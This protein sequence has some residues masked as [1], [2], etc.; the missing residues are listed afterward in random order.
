MNWNN[1]MM[2]SDLLPAIPEDGIDNQTA[3]MEIEEGGSAAQESRIEQLMVTMLDERDKLLEQLQESQEHSK[4][5]QE[6]VREAERSREAL[7]RRLDMQTEHL[8]TEIQTLTKELSQQREQLL[9]KDEEI[10]ELKAER[11]NTRLLLEHLECLVSRHERSL[12]MTVMKR[13]NQNS[14]GVSS[15]VEVLKALKSLFEHHKALDEKVRE[16]LRVAMERVAS[17][18]DELNAKSDENCSLKAL[19]AKATAEAE[20]NCQNLSGG[21]GRQSNGSAASAESAAR[22]VELEDQLD[23]MKQELTNSLKQISELTNRNSEIE[24]QASSAQK[25]I[26]TSKEQVAKLKHQLQ[27]ME[28]QR[29]EQEAL[30][31]TLENRYMTAQRE[32]TCLRDLKD[33][34]EH[35]LANNDAAC[36]LNEEK[37]HSLQERLE[38]S[39]K[40]LAQSLKKAES[41]PSVEAELQQR[42]EALTAAEQKQVSAEERVQQ[43]Q[44]QVEERSSELERAVQRE[45][46][47]EEHNQRLSSTVDKLLSES[48][49]RLQLHLKERM[50]ALDEKNRLTQQLEQTKKLYDQAER[51]KD[52]LTRDNENLRQEIEAVRQQLYN[53]RTAQFQSRFSSSYIPA[54]LPQVM[55]IPPYARNQPQMQSAANAPA[56]NAPIYSTLGTR[57]PQKGRV[58]ALADDPTKV[59]TLNEQE[60]DRLQQ[61]HV[62]ANVQQAFSNSSSMLNINP[63]AMMQSSATNI[64]PPNG[65]VVSEPQMQNQPQSS[66]AHAL[67]SMLQER[68]DAINTEIRII[69]Q[70]KSHAER[71]AEQLEHR[72]WSNELGP[73]QPM[74]GQNMY[75]LEEAAHHNISAR[76]TP[77]NSPQHDLLATK[78]STLPA[79]ASTSAYM[80]GHD[81]Y[82]NHMSM[83]D[84]VLDREY[85]MSRKPLRLD[86]MQQPLQGRMT[87]ENDS[88]DRM[89]PASSVS[90]NEPSG[91]ISGKTKKRSSSTSGLKSLGRIFGTKKGKNQ[92]SYRRMMDAGAYSDS[93]MS[94][95]AEGHVMNN[96]ANVGKT[97]NG[98]SSTTASTADFDR[99]KR[100]KHELLE[101]AMKARTPF[102]LWNGPTVVAWLELWVGMPAWYV[103]ACRANVKSGAIMSALSDQ[104]I[105]R[106]IGISNPLHR[107]KLRLAI[108]EMVSLT[109]PS[110]PRNA[111]TTLAFGDMNHEWIGN[112]WLPSLGL[113]KYR[114]AFMECL[115]DA[116]ML[117]HLSKRDLRVHLK[118]VDNF[119]RTSLQYGILCLKKLNYERKILEERRRSCEN[120]NKDVVVWSCERVSRWVEEIGLG[121]FAGQLRDSG[122]HGALIALDETFDAQAF[123]LS[124][125][126]P[127]QD[128]AA[129]QILERH[130][131][132]L[133]AECRS[134]PSNMMQPRHTRSSLSIA[135]RQKRRSKDSSP[136]P[137]SSLEPVVSSLITGEGDSIW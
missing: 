119:H 39:E 1:A 86:H 124:L 4:R 87:D 27:E 109:S 120:V 84:S 76:S 6:Q 81:M 28:V 70:E 57:R 88:I 58:A 123:A 113:G 131:N 55:E 35:Q 99:R 136:A 108:Q 7:V 12:R 20:E 66:D 130:F 67:A 3:S 48:N 61:A 65:P 118:M 51:M 95:A 116:R 29:G 63:N 36:R 54:V 33:K 53:A 24:N 93:E 133:V 64:R 37:V 96:S 73:N 38:L 62:L 23:R 10:V 41:L 107:L 25:D 44:R 49:D 9:E 105:Q 56:V 85:N 127:P 106:E 137:R 2:G 94:S 112:E 78:Y 79:N 69:Q 128:E 31:E 129:R 82:Q 34:L 40:Q 71:V 42:M 121:L 16:R 132:Q 68:L 125:Q 43:L 122:V 22:V 45:K 104:E 60:W 75:G 17:L 77:R 111:R 32:A 47:N 80:G 11:N 110:A 97:M 74:P 18:E 98:G 92:D 102:A 114:G 72:A 100:K 19:L 21:M 90:S 46:M 5:L 59:Q 117:E 89:S 30:I 135:Q 126:I 13:Q 91:F 52:R 115:L 83:D 134:D 26:R 15:E 101:E 14:A 103:A 50:Q 8:P